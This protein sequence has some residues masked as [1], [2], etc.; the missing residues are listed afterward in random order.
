MGEHAVNQ[1]TGAEERKAF[2]RH[3][4]SD[5]HALERM[6]SERM[7]ETGIQRIGAEQEFCLVDSDFR[8][9]T[10]GPE[11]LA[12]IK[13]EHFTT[14]LAKYNL[15]IN[16]DPLELTG[17]CFSTMEEQLTT[18]IDRA[19]AVA[20]EHNQNL[21]LTGILPTVRRSEVSTCMSQHD[22][23]SLVRASTS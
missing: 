20:S 5:I 2:I 22:A 4:L 13:D 9:S 7:F 1:T 17:R 14:E 11:V 16:L 12:D 10:K 19:R 21:V 6:L 15:E 23:S 3:L 8:P 18:L